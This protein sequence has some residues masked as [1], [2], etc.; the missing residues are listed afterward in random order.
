MD[1]QLEEILKE[2]FMIKFAAALGVGPTIVKPYGYD[3]LISANEIE[4]TMELVEMDRL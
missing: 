3:L 1:T 2:I 4:F